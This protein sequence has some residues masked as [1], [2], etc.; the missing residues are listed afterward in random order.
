MWSS[1]DPQPKPPDNGQHL[2]FHLQET[3][4]RQVHSK[5]ASQRRQSQPSD[6]GLRQQSQAAQLRAA[7][8]AATATINWITGLK[9]VLG[10]SLRTMHVTVSSD[11][12]GIGAAI[13]ALQ[14]MRHTSCIAGVRQLMS[15]ERDTDTRSFF[16]A[17][18]EAPELMFADI[19]DRDGMRGFDLRSHSRQ[20]LPTD[21]DLYV[22][23]PPCCPFS[24]RR[25][26]LEDPFND[27]KAGSTG[28]PVLG[29]CVGVQ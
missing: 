21:V 3:A 1:A 11:C 28:K 19:T 14:M 13:E 25:T 8:W 7:H 18:H 15:S 4:G 23:G 12:E 29:A 22:C 24:M 27:P 20:P 6:E 17:R 5:V 10:S 2:V 9:S 16:L 26:Q